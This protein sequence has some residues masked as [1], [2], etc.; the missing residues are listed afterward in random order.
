MINIEKKVLQGLNLPK[1]NQITQHCY[2]IKKD[3]YVFFCQEPIT[4][5]NIFYELSNLEKIFKTS[6][7][8]EWKTFIIVAKTEDTFQKN[9]LFF[10]DGISTFVVFLLINE[11]RAEIY[12][13]DKWIFPLGLNFKKFVRNIKSILQESDINGAVNSLGRKS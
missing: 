10:F 13:N 8:P 2:L 12:L 1:A 7:F 6:F 11:Q 5:E 9:D 4:K 3:R